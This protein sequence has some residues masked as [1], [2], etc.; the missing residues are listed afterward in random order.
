MRYDTLCPKTI[1]FSQ[2]AYDA[3]SDGAGF[4][5]AELI[6]SSTGGV[7]DGDGADDDTGR[8]VGRSIRCS[9]L[10]SRHFYFVESAVFFSFSD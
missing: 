8:S 10:C 6:R 4:Y 5:I 1:C 2:P 7:V 3:L 9:L